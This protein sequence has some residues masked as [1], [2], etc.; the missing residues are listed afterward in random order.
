[1]GS[2]FAILAF[3][4][5][6]FFG[7][8]LVAAQD[9]T[10]VLEYEDLLEIT[11]ARYDLSVSCLA[12]ANSM[13]EFL[14]EGILNIDTSCPPYD[15]DELGQG[16][17][18][19]NY[20]VALGD[21][22]TKIAERFDMSVSCIQSTN[23]L[24]DPNLIY[25]GQVLTISDDCANNVSVPLPREQCFGDR[26]PGREVDNGVYIVQ[27]GDMLDFIGCDLNLSTSCLITLNN[28]EDRR[29]PLLIGQELIVGSQCTGWEDPSLPSNNR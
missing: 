1:M 4:L 9:E 15:A 13:E 20:T 5:T 6:A 21:N 23:A 3:L 12:E 18:S 8:N 14:S 16:G 11:A 10:I 19:S 2:R 22:L 7:V 25:V 27:E 28:L 29:Q 17:G 24:L 26:N